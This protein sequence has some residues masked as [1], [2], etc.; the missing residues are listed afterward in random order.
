MNCQRCNSPAFLN[1]MNNSE[2]ILICDFCGFY[3]ARLIE[4]MHYGHPIFKRILLEPEGV[5]LTDT[6]N[7]QYFSQKQRDLLL[8]VHKENNGYTYYDP[9]KRKW[10]I[11]SAKKTEDINALFYT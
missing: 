10:R 11:K 8:K 7:Y 5:I 6:K 4:H 1:E 3:S 9:K 2:F